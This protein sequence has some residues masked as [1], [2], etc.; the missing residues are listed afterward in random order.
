LA[1]ASRAAMPAA[2][3]G[4]AKEQPG[5]SAPAPGR[6]R[7]GIAP[8]RSPALGPSDRSSPIDHSPAS[9]ASDL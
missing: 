3:I 4:Q 5:S 8:Q 1:S 7:E 9:D 6:E 2:K